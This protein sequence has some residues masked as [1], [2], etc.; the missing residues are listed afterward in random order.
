MSTLSERLEADPELKKR[1]KF[2]TTSPELTASQEKFLDDY[3][4]SL[5]YNKINVLELLRKLITKQVLRDPGKSKGGKWDIFC[6]H[7][8]TLSYLLEP[9]ETTIEGFLSIFHMEEA[10]GSRTLGETPQ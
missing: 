2:M 3:L 10:E 5:D 9:A 4:N 8:R 1:W 6:G 7:N